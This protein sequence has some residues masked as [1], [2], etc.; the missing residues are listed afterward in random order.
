MEPDPRPI[1]NPDDALKRV[2]TRI[3]DRLLDPVALPAFICGG[4]PGRSTKTNAR[5]HCR[6]PVV[7]ALDIKNFFGS[8]T[9]RQIAA[10]WRRDFG[11]SSEVAWLLTRLTTYS[12][13]LPQG[14]PTS[15]ALANLVI[16]PIAAE[17]HNKCRS[18]GLPFSIDVDD[19][20]I[21]G[22]GAGQMISDVARMIAV[23]G[24]P[25]FVRAT[26]TPLA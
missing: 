1:D 12:G 18:R 25:A 26:M 16:T 8:V 6:Q 14:A 5:R 15:T 20:T 23:G 11:A 19:I 21:S 17:I 2:Q 24:F 10:V 22:K 4:V 7:V 13:H 9:N 3:K